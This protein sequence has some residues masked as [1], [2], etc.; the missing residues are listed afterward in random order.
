MLLYNADTSTIRQG[1]RF[2]HKAYSVLPITNVE[3]HEANQVSNCHT[4]ALTTLRRRKT[5]NHIQ[6]HIAT[7]GKCEGT[8]V[9]NTRQNPAKTNPR[10]RPRTTPVTWNKQH[11]EAP[12]HVLQHTHPHAQWRPHRPHKG[13]DPPRSK[14]HTQE[15][16]TQ[17]PREPTWQR[18]IRST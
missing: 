17:P 10:A 1:P 12:Q 18:P 4:N 11:W 7:Y 14:I 5:V 16:I 6:C 13:Q 3:Q 2:Y 8:I 9:Q 15:A